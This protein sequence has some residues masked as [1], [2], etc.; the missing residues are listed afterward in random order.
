MEKEQPKFKI[1]IVAPCHIQPTKEWIN[2]LKIV[3]AKYKVIIVHD[4]W[5]EELDLPSEWD[6]YDYG[7]QK[8]EM[9]EKL[10]EQFKV[11]HKSSAIRNFGHW[12]AWRDGYDIIIGLDSDCNAPPDFIA[13]HLEALMSNSYGWENPIKN[14]N[15][16]P[17]GFPYHERSRKTILN[18]GLWENELDV[19]GLDRVHNGKPPKDPMIGKTEIA[20]SFIPLCGMNFAMWAYAV[21][22]FLFLPN[23]DD[24]DLKF[25]RY[26]DIWGGYIFQKLIQK[27]KDTITF[28]SPIVFHDTIVDAEADAELEKDGISLEELFYKTIDVCCEEIGEQQKYEMLFKRFSD[29]A[30]EVMEGSVFEA[31]SPSIKMWVDLFKQDE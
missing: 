13:K 8:R 20:H 11:F 7:R 23:F 28:G 15:W 25:R 19:N 26:D 24:G 10:Y 16:F 27:N 6:I 21:P 18:I 9:G 2:S 5:K 4:S 3:G 12:L 29:R 22:A 1:A 14:T 17:R 30:K 31:L